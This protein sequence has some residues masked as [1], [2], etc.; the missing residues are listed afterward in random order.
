MGVRIHILF[1]FY[2]FDFKTFF[3]TKMS[4]VGIFILNSL[5]FLWIF[6]QIIKTEAKILL[7]IFLNFSF[8]STINRTINC[9]NGEWLKLPAYLISGLLPVNQDF[10]NH[11]LFPHFQGSLNG[12]SG[13][14]LFYIEKKENSADNIFS[15]FW[16]F[17]LTLLPFLFVPWI[18]LHFLAIF[19]FPPFGSCQKSNIS[20]S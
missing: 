15:C 5:G 11:N 2:S 4:Y 3:T 16:C 8:M 9:V 18:Y 6:E 1:L 13:S 20:I 14:V 12:L 10:T 19:S 7:E 17:F